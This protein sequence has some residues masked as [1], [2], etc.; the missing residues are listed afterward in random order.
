MDVRVEIQ[1]SIKSVQT[2]NASE[3]KPRTA[4]PLRGGGSCSEN[5]WVFVIAIVVI[6]IGF[7]IMSVGSVYYTNNEKN[8]DARNA[9]IAGSVILLVGIICCLGAICQ[10]CQDACDK[11]CG[12]HLSCC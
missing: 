4:P 10:A 6:I 2:N 7:I 9:L 1:E 11:C 3:L 5:W 8:I 12:C